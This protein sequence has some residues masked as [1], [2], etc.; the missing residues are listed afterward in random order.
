MAAASTATVV[1]VDRVIEAAAAAIFAVVADASRHPEIDGS[2][3]FIRP[4]EGTPQ[5]LALGATFGMS[6]KLG[7]PSSAGASGAM[8]SRGPRAGRR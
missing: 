1:S 8:S 4:K 7:V 2:G 5:V 3:S 6:M